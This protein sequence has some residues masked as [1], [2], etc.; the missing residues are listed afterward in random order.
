MTASD[1]ALL[2]QS[3]THLSGDGQW[4]TGGLDCHRHM[5]TAYRLYELKERTIAN[6]KKLQ[7]AASDRPAVTCQ[8]EE[9]WID[10][11]LLIKIRLR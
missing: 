2:L 3:F 10:Q 1:E 8:V 11:Q 9:G 4:I 6:Y 5:A 7:A